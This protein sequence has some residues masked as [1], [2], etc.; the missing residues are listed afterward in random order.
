MSKNLVIDTSV[1]LTY[2]A[3]NKLYRLIDAINRYDLRVFVN[4]QLIAELQGNI[5]NCLRVKDVDFSILLIAIMEATTHITPKSNF[6][7]SPDAKDNFL[8][9][10]AID[11]KS[12]VIVTQEKALLNFKDSPVKI[13][14]LKWFKE[15]YP[16]PL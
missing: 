10:I 14:D 9:D 2:A 8:F 16:V 1:Y 13:H 6:I 4:N 11:T 3:Y 5:G 7:G 15:A 12:D